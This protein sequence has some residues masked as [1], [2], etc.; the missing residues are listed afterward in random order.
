M[1]DVSRLKQI[2][3]EI[4]RTG[5]AAVDPAEAVSRHLERRGDQVVA[6]SAGREVGRWS[7]GEEI[8]RV[9][10]VGAGKAS[11][12]M[13]QAAEAALGDL[14]TDGLVVVKTGHGAP[15]RAV[16]VAE[17]AHPVPDEAGQRGAERLARLVDE[18]DGST[19]VVVLISGG[20][21]ALTPLPAEGITL[22]EK[23]AVTDLLLGAGADI[24]EMNALRKHLSALKG[25]QLA[26]RA[27][28]APVLALILSDVVGDRLDVIAS[29]PTVPDPTTFAVA[30]AVLRRRGLWSRVPE[31]VRR[32]LERGEAGE[33]D[34]TPKPGDRCFDRSRH[35][36]VGTNAAALQACCEAARARGFS[37]LLLASTIEGETREVARVHGSIA[38]ELRR[39]GE[40]RTGRPVVPP[41]CLVS[42]GETT[43]T[44]RGQGLGGRN[45][46]FALAA[47][48]DIE[49]QQAMV[50]LSAGTDGTDGPTDAA[51][52]VVAG[53]T[54]ARARAAG[55]DPRHHLDENDAYPL[56]DALDDLI[57]TGPTH[58]NVMDIHLALVDEPTS[59][60]S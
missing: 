21:S 46:E 26:R 58:T 30:A 56:F 25:G 43:V 54:L 8:D 7:V 2:A 9:L 51:G 1:A 52:A 45:Q 35:L 55:L 38:R 33:L 23:Q 14:V 10:L 4:F 34:E 24:G 31:A 22:G 6:H 27:A 16:E 49:G 12:R 39:A 47:A 36:L 48:H 15:T 5:L 37:P 60:S 53:D 32:R 42:G 17:A 13:A 59:S 41:A 19:L 29:G 57:R 11:A 50:I 40:G 28:P 18:A 3:V 20:G 44:I